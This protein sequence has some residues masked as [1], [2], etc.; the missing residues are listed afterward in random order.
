MESEDGYDFTESDGENSEDE[1]MEGALTR[2][3]DL[4][5][6]TMKRRNAQVW[7]KFTSTCLSG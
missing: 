4:P 6:L 7:T 2:L 1:E 3:P 5:D